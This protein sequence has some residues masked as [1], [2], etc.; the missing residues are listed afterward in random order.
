MLYTNST[1]LNQKKDIINCAAERSFVDAKVLQLSTQVSRASSQLNA[2]GYIVTEMGYKIHKSCMD[3]WGT[4][5]FPNILKTSMNKGMHCLA[6]LAV[7]NASANASA[8]E[9]IFFIYIIFF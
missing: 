3:R 5:E 2:D 8:I 9:K 6:D 7:K 4:K 1:S